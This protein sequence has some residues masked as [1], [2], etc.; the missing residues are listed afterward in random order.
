MC[1]DRS[2]GVVD[3]STLTSDIDRL[4]MRSVRAVPSGGAAPA[5]AAAA[6]WTKVQGSLKEINAGAAAPSPAGKGGKPMSKNMYQHQFVGALVRLAQLKFPSEP[7]LY[8]RLDAF[9]RKYL[10]G[11]VETELTWC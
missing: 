6:G 3:K 5:G 10:V 11:H 9:C 4:Y 8:R 1:G 7:T 2:V